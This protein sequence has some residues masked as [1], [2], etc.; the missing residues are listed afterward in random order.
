MNLSDA[1]EAS[2]KRVFQLPVVQAVAAQLIQPVAFLHS[3][4]VV[5]A[6]MSCMFS[7]LAHGRF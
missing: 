7:I 2:Y 5:H 1:R 4:G 6:G 3:Q